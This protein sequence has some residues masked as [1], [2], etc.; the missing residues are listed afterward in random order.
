M[1]GGFNPK[2]LNPNGW[3]LQ[4]KSNELQTSFYF[5]GSQV[6]INLGLEKTTQPSIKSLKKLTK[7]EKMFFHK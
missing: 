1:S 4:T 6:P 5:G 2:V 3:K 7:K